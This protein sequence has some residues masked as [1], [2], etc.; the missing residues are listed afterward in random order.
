MLFQQIIFYILLLQGGI[1]F[2]KSSVFYGVCYFQTGVSSVRSYCTC[3]R[4]F[5]KY[6][7]V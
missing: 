3:T 7:F 5:I 2:M 1:D 4:Y 6:F